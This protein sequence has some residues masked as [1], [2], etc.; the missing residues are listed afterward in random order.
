MVPA[1]Y[2]DFLEHGEIR[3]KVTAIGRYGYIFLKESGSRRL[4]PGMRLCMSD[5][6]DTP[7]ITVIQV[8]GSDISAR[9]LPSIGQKKE[10][11][12]VGHIFTTGS[13]WNRP[14]GTWNLAFTQEQ[15]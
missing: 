4:K 8:N 10:Q 2:K 1:L 14:E 11:I 12:R 9:Q 13:N 3:A 7:D 6:N 15:P 5:S